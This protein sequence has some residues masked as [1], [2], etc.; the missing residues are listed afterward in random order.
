M[1]KDLT[2]ALGLLD[3][4]PITGKHPADYYEALNDDGFFSDRSF[5]LNYYAVKALL[6]R[7][8]MWEGSDASIALARQEALDVIRDGERLGL[9]RWITTDVVGTDPVHSTEHIASLNI[10]AFTDRLKD[11]YLYNF[12]EG[13]EYNAIKL[14]EGNM[15]S[16]YEEEG[17]GENADYRRE[18]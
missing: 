1:I 6:A 17:D 16:I 4:E 7:V 9:Y 18:K 8:Y 11:F 10:P 3:D 12:L 5:R 14:S 2:D 13:T 15:I